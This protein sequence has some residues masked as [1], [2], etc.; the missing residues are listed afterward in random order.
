MTSIGR[1]IIRPFTE[2][3]KS[4]TGLVISAIPLVYIASFG[5]ALDAA[6]T[7]ARRDY[8]LPEWEEWWR[9]YRNGFMAVVCWLLYML[10]ALLVEVFSGGSFFR[11]LGGETVVYGVGDVIAGVL[12]VIAYYVVP[13]AWTS[14]SLKE[15]FASMFDLRVFKVALS[16][17][18]VTAI[19]VS[20]LYMFVLTSVLVI[21]TLPLVKTGSIIP[22]VLLDM[23]L[24]PLLVTM[25][26]LCGEAWS[27]V[28]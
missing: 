4:L 22:L 16:R 27:Q 19:L 24:F 12:A 8:Y 10:P 1:A 28:R 15:S 6:Q 18:Y 20:T 21:I 13:A 9:L 26:T 14:L 11:A 3:G 17:P 7:A 5:Y 23:A 25:M 2:F